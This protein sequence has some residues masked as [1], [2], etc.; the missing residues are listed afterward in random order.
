MGNGMSIKVEAKPAA[1]ILGK[2]DWAL[3]SFQI[4]DALESGIKT[5]YVNVSGRGAPGSK[6]TTYEL[7]LEYNC[8]PYG[9]VPSYHLKLILC[10][11]YCNCQNPSNIRSD[12]IRG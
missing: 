8:K 5:K 4:T 12:R 2:K 10:H 6:I 3:W 9:I 1:F 11:S 7:E